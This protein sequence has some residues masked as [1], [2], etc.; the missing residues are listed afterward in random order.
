MNRFRARAGG[1]AIGVTGLCLVA[2]AGGTAGF[3][4]GED[5]ATAPDRP[6]HI[7]EG[8]CDTLNPA[9]LYVL[10]DLS[11]AEGEA[12]YGGPGTPSAVQSGVTGVDVALAD[13]AA[14]DFSIV[15]HESADHIENYIACGEIGGVIAPGEAE[16]VETLAVGL[17]TLNDSGQSGIAVLRGEGAATTVTIYLADGLANGG[18]A[19]AADVDHGGHAAATEGAAAVEI[20]DFAYSPDPLTIAAGDSVTWTNADSFAHTATGLDR[21]VLQSG[22]LN[23]GESFT[24]TFSAAGTYEYFCEFHPQMTGTVIVE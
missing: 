15:V 4:Q 11:L 1:L 8:S 9:P 6:N 17:R 12:Q 3:A 10:T 21:D 22:T 13:L 7:H 2:L 5:A 14:G 20:S 16:G 18:T 19:S 24:A 23:E